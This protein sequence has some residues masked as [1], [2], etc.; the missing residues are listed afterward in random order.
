MNPKKDDPALQKLIAERDALK[1]LAARAQADLQNAKDRL[2]KQSAEMRAYA[3][4]GFILRLLP[5]VD[6]LHR[7]LE[8]VSDEGVQSVERDLL[9]ILETEGVTKIESLGQPVDPARHEVLQTGPG[10][11]GKILEVF[12]EGYELHG[13]VLRPAKVK[14]GDAL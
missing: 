5:I 3:L 13:K 14:V 7:S 9:K 11:E 4:E 6:N 1:E 8:H 10:E 2:E 12:E